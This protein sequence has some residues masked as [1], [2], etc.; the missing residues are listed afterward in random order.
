MRPEG[1][2]KQN[3]STY[4]TTNESKHIMNKLYFWWLTV[5]LV[6]TGIFWT[7][8]NGI[9]FEVWARDHT[10]ITSLLM[11]LATYVTLYN[12]YLAYNIDRMSID[13]RQKMIGRSF[14]LSDIAMGLAILGASAA[15]II[16]F[17]LGDGIKM[18][19]IAETLV[20]KW[21]E[22]APAFYPNFVGLAV[23][24]YIK[25][26]TYFIAEDYLDE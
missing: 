9:L 24:L 23:A 22:L 16:L 10:Y 3:P 5:L 15:I 21:S 4:H 2:W 12:G 13:V 18:D 11:I 25:F 7:G 6:G 17:S 20:S 19:S 1:A 14:F 8:Y 26:Q